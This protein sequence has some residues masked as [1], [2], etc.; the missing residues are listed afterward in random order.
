MP[1]KSQTVHNNTNVTVQCITCGC[2]HIEIVTNETDMRCGTI[3]NETLTC[4][5]MV[6]NPISIKC[7]AGKYLHKK[8]SW[9][10]IAV[11]TGIMRFDL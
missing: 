11:E 5:F 8:S 10:T 9:N 3:R 4:W 2:G 6:L 1:P 7:M